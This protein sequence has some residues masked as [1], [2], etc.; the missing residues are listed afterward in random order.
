MESNEKHRALGLL[1]WV[2][3]GTVVESVDGANGDGSVLV[4]LEGGEQRRA[5]VAL[6][7]G[8]VSAGDR[9]LV[10]SNG[11]LDAGGAYVVVLLRRAAGAGR[12]VATADGVSATVSARGEG[13]EVLRVSSASGAV[14]FEY[15]PA[16]GR[17]SATAA[18]GELSVSAPAGKLLLHGEEGVEISSGRA[19]RVRAKDVVA[20]ERA[21][22]AGEGGQRV[23]LDKRGVSV[24]GTA[25]FA[26]AEK[27]EG[28]I[29]DARLVF[30]T[31]ST[32]AKVARSVVETVDMRVGRLVERARNVLREVEE[33]HQLRAGRERTVV[34][35]TSHTTA[36]RVVM[37]ASEEVKLDGQKIRLG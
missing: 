9:V 12:S 20:L 5:S 26:L 36:K 19:V 18:S 8:A 16:T 2:L 27:L 6:A 32:T 22:E 25:V 14:L 35:E 37:T 10:L 1:P 31:V 28:R 4:A 11:E 33:L 17:S 30:R 13:G 23:W 21:G 34:R 15:D 24:A 29:G 3:E 7:A